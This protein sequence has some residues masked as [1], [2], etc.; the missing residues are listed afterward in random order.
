MNRGEAIGTI[1]EI[2]GADQY[3][4]RDTL[5]DEQTEAIKMSLNAL[6]NPE[7]MSCG[8]CQKFADESTDGWGWCEYHDRSAMCDD[9]ACRYYE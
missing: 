5:T 9:K 2:F 3:G 6:E 1:K 8:Y 7:C 4:I